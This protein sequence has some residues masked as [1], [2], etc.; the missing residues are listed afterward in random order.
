MKLKNQTLHFYHLKVK[1][2]ETV[3]GLHSVDLLFTKG[4]FLK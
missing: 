1:E 3:T 2:K 4:L